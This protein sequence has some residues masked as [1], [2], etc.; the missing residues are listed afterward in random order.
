MTPPAS[1][2][3]AQVFQVV[4]Q[5]A[6]MGWRGPITNNTR[7]DDL[8]IDSLERVTLLVD[9][10]DLLGFPIEEEF[11]FADTVGRFA[12]LV[13]RAAANRLKVAA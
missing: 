6:P 9:I 11:D 8:C 2:I 4:R 1:F 3:R 12:D 5:Y 7:F 10:E 13:E